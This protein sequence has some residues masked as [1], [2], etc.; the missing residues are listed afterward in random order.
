MEKIEIEIQN[1]QK[2]YDED[3][4]AKKKDIESHKTKLTET[5]A[6]VEQEVQKVIFSFKK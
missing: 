5:L 6:Q 2:T 4:E 3:Y 1:Q